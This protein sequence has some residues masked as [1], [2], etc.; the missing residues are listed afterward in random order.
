[1]ITKEELKNNLCE[2]YRLLSEMAL[3]QGGLSAEM[4]RLSNNLNLLRQ[5][6]NALPDQP[7]QPHYSEKADKW[8]CN[9]CDAEE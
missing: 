4:D 5:S 8:L 9:N 1:M 3:R 7:E 6:I 2:A